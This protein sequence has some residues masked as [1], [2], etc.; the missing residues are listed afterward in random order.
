MSRDV[1]MGPVKTLY[2][3]DDQFKSWSANSCKMSSRGFLL[4]VVLHTAWG[5]DSR[6]KVHVLKT[7]CEYEGFA[8]T[9]KTNRNIIGD[10]PIMLCARTASWPLPQISYRFADSAS[11]VDLFFNE[12]CVLDSCVVWQLRST[13]YLYT[14]MLSLQAEAKQK[15]QHVK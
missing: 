5:S 4:C 9:R 1:D 10:G 11:N 15:E 7:T 3:S 2:Q 6:D 12:H 8:A 14:L 13:R